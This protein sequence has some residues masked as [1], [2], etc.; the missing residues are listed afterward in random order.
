M[1]KIKL[2]KEQC[3][4]FSHG[5]VLNVCGEFWYNLPMWLKETEE[6]GVY[7]MYLNSDSLPGYVKD[8]IAQLNSG[9]GVFYYDK[10][11]E[12]NGKNDQA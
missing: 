7:E 9:K 5:T 2:T 6:S 12:D 11:N 1:V 8:S 4:L 10:T 3:E